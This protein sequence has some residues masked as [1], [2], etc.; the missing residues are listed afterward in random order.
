MRGAGKIDKKNLNDLFKNKL[1]K[2]PSNVIQGP[3]FGVDISIVQIN[4]SHSLIV[5]SDPTSFIP[6]LGIKESAW[7]SVILTANDVATSGF[8]PRYAQFVLNLTHEMTDNELTEYWEHIHSFCVEIGISITGGHTGFADIGP[9]TLAGGTTMFTIA[10]SAKVKC[11]SFAKADQEL[12]LTKSAALSGASIL[13]KSFPNY[14]REN[15]GSDVYERLSDSFYQ[16]S[17]IPE[18]KILRSRPDIMQ[19][20]VAMHDVTEGG[21][22]GAIYELC[23][24][25][26]V[27]V[28]VNLDAIKI[29]DPQKQ[30]CNLFQIDPLRSIGAGSLLVACQKEV[31]VAIIKELTSHNIPAAV[32][33]RTLPYEEGKRIGTADEEN[34]L[35]YEDKDPYWEAFFSAIRKQLK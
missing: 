34:E 22:L 17:I 33:G 29:G 24:A 10:E 11:A 27:G 13:A 3:A 32:V 7:L 2:Q 4:D 21:S 12:I 25:S 16:T 1:G 8:L 30:V 15:L 28:R 19:G 9:S 5:A 26:R 20:I 6:S 23:E 35:I 14:T 31:S 18:I